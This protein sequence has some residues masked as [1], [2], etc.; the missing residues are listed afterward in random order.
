M[1][2]FAVSILTKQGHKVKVSD[3]YGMK[4]KMVADEDDFIEL[5]SQS[6]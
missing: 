6:F 1:K 4:L 2:D 5:S 3:L